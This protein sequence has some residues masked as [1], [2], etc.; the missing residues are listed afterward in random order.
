MGYIHP[1]RV[2]YTSGVALG[3]Y[4]PSWVYISSYT[5]YTHCINIIYTLGINMKTVSP[6]L[7]KIFNLNC[8]TKNSPVTFRTVSRSPL[9]WDIK[10]LY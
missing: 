10:N 4:D 3:V 8:V 6:F 9:T 1:R 2:I 5:T 7:P